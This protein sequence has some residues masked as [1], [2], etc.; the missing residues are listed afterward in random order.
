MAEVLCEKEQGLTAEAYLERSRM[1]RCGVWAS[2]VE[3]FTAAIFAAAQWLIENSDLYKEE[4]ISL[5]PSWYRPEWEGVDEVEF[6]INEADKNLEHHDN[7]IPESSL[8]EVDTEKCEATAETFS[9]RQR[10]MDN[11]DR[12]KPLT[13]SKICKAELRNA[14]RRAAHSIANIFFKLKKLQMLQIRDLATTALRKVKGSKKAYTAGQLKKEG[15][16]EDLLHHDEGYRVLKTLRSSPPYWQ[17]RQ[18][19]LFAMIRQLGKPTFFATFSAAETRWFDLLRVLYRM[20]HNEDITDD[21]LQKLT[22]QE[23]SKLIQKDP[24]TCAR[25]FHHRVQV[26]FRTVI[27]SDLQ[28][29]GKVTDYFFRVEFQQRGSPHIHCLLWVEGAPEADKDTD[30]DMEDFIG[31]D[32]SF[33]DF[34]TRVGLDENQYVLA[35]RS[36]LDRT[37]V[38]LQR[39]PS[40]SRMNSRNDAISQVW[41]ANTDV[42]FI[43]DEYACAVYIVT[44]ISKSQRGMSDMLR[45]AADEAKHGNHSVRE[46]VRHIANKFLNHC[47]VS[48]QEAVYLLLQLP[49]CRSTRDVVFVNT[50]PPSQRV[51]ILKNTALLETLEDDDTD[52][53]FS[54]LIDRYAE[55]PEKLEHLCLAEF[56]AW[57][58]VKKKP[59]YH[60]KPERPGDFL[61]ENDYEEDVTDD[62]WNADAS[63]GDE[64]RLPDGRVLCRRT[65]SKILRCVR[66][67]RESEAENHFREKLMLYLPWRDEQKDIIGQCESYCERYE[68][69]KEVVSDMEK[70]FEP[71]AAAVDRAV[72][73]VQKE[74]VD[75]EAWDEVAPQAQDME[76]RDG[77]GKSRCILAIYQALIR[78]LSSRPGDKP[79]C[80]RVRLTAPT[81]KAAYNIKGITLHTAFCLPANQSLSNYVKL[82]AGRLNTLRSSLAELRVLIIDEISMV[83]ANMLAFVDQ[84]LREVM[85]CDK[86]F[87]GVSVLAVGDLYQL[88]P[89]MDR[90]VFQPSEGPY[91]GLAPVLWQD[92]FRLFELTEVMRQKDDKIFA[93]ILNRIREGHHTRD[94]EEMIKS[95]IKSGVPH[96]M[97]HLF[98]SCRLVSEHNIKSLDR[99]QSPESHLK[100]RDSMMGEVSA[101]LKAELL[102]KAR[103][104][105][106]QQTQSLPLLL[107][108]KVGAR[109]MLVHNIDIG[110]GLV[111]G[112]SGTLH[113][114]GHTGSEGP[115]HVSVLWVEFDDE[116]VGKKTREQ[117]KQLYTQNISTKWTPVFQSVKQFRVGKRQ[118]VAVLRRQFPLT[119][120]SAITIHKSQGS[121]LENVAVSFQG[122]VHHHL[123]Y[124]ALSRAR[125]MAGLHLLDFDPKKI[126]VS[127]KVKQ[128]MERLRQEPV[129]PC[130]T[131]LQQFS[132]TG[133]VIVF[134]NSRSLHKHIADLR[135]DRNLLQASLMFI[136][137]TWE[138]EQDDPEHYKI[139]D[140]TV[141]ARNTASVKG[142]RS[143]AGTLV[144]TRDHSLPFSSSASQKCSS[145]IEITVVDASTSVRGLVVVGIYCPPHVSITVLCAELRAV[146]QQELTSHTHVIIGGD[147]NSDASRGL[148]RPLQEFCEQFSLRQLIK[149]PTTDYDSTLDLVLTNVPEP[150][151]A[152]VLESCSVLSWIDAFNFVV[153]D[154]AFN[155]VVN[156]I[157]FNFVVSD[158]AFNFAVSDIAFNFVV[159]DIAFKH[160]SD[161]IQRIQGNAAWTVDDECL[162]SDLMTEDHGNN[163]HR[164]GAH[165][166]IVIGQMSVIDSHSRKTLTDPV[167]HN[168]PDK[169]SFTFGVLLP[170]CH[171]LAKALVLN[172]WI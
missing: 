11:S 137:E 139:A 67:S 124:V 167:F 35:I 76:N 129:V 63:S 8:K 153:N 104:M 97:L 13:Y 130:L 152:G 62:I 155:F 82:D 73:Q 85:G 138:H 47:E 81:G 43:L 143:H 145:G 103:D 120:C 20:E 91:E 115:E 33:E 50:S 100:A 53:T 71:I 4:G 72:D 172:H 27:L 55:R 36:D 40:E 21:E 170:Q 89:V 66:F 15:A 98:I 133:F 162:T 9:E 116:G 165:L 163:S 111:N 46:Q 83:G 151:P 96:N 6:T 171:L 49:M 5:D 39:T 25:H 68:L 1:M 149:D 112:A 84:R 146:I 154:I 23:R 7:G 117:N 87:G 119:A 107:T 164:L 134:H 56:A 161:I 105:T 114:V 37:K 94:D 24:V 74:G 122:A 45:D 80:L 106:V 65:K 18:K 60:K 52:V 48:A 90:W 10:R 41:M 109:Y 113:Q 142:C 2:E 123:V 12:F 150:T 126:R 125:T 147:F 108:V 99:L 38:F 79:D 70:C 78:Y 141:V 61:P 42:Q 16:V 131:D 160:P 34:L 14:D 31:D 166:H 3:I 127:P 156:D 128:E 75:E 157:A 30:T 110:D 28:P 135:A 44:Y 121:T 59:P 144:Y 69:L 57:Y 93:D 54:S 136:F 102:Q 58:D 86:P 168:D 169:P 32:I 158:I 118:N 92:L 26:L 22:W 140:F 159:N 95:C 19:D 51:G 29:L 132:T 17:A 88:R 77:V 148:P 64:Y 101:A